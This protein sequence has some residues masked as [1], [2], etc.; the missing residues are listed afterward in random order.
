MRGRKIPVTV[1]ATVLCGFAADTKAISDPG[2]QLAALR[3]IFPGTQISAATP[4]RT[5]ESKLEKPD[6]DGLYFPDALSMD[7]TYSVTGNPANEI[8]D[9]AAGD[10]VTNSVSQIRRVRM[11]L[12]RWPQFAASHLLAVIQ[13]DFADANPP[14]ACPSIGMLIELTRN[15]SEWRVLNRY[16]L[17]T[18][19]H[20]GIQRI[21]VAD[22]TGGGADELI[23]ESDFGGAGIAASGLQIFDL[24]KGRFDEILNTVSCLRSDDEGGYIQV[25]DMQRTRQRQGRRFCVN[26][27]MRAEGGRPAVPLKTIT[28]WFNRGSGVDRKW[29]RQREAELEPLAP[30]ASGHSGR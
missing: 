15:G 17:D 25:L 10:V 30:R 13:Y 3:G 27:T 20:S 26:K 14:M 9:C 29:I 8:E 2:L 7:T 21:E 11:K 23:I 1:L 12:F 4:A 19:H 22:L 5:D 18:V 6:L 28:A 24:R 16:L